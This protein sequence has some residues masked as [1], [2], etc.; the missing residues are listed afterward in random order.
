MLG[1]KYDTR[2]VHSISE[3]GLLAERFP[4]NIKLFAAH[5][6]GKMLAGVIIYE[7]RQ[8]AHAQYIGANDD[9][10]SIGAQDVIISYL[11][12]DYYAQKPYFDFGIST[13]EEGRRLNTGLVENKQSYGARAIV[14]DFYEI[15]FGPT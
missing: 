13:E 10:R 4:D 14:Y 6:A 8:V 12:D 11:V 9:G 2:P 5:Q 1:D 15:S 3:I 7:S